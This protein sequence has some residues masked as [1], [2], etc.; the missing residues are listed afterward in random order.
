MMEIINQD[1]IKSLAN[2]EITG[3]ESS[4]NV[5]VGANSLPPFVDICLI[6]VIPWPCLVDFGCIGIF[7]CGIYK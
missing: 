4:N 1:N 7:L 2:Q 3:I 5:E 6:D